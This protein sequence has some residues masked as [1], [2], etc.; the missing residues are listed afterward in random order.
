MRASCFSLYKRADRNQDCKKSEIEEREGDDIALGRFGVVRGVLAEG[1]EAGKRGDEGARAADVDAQQQLAVAFGE[2]RQ[3]HR[4]GHVTDKLTGKGAYDQLVLCQQSSEQLAH[5]LDPRHISGKDEEE[6]EG[7]KQRIIDLF[8]R[9]AIHEEQDGGDHGESEKIGDSAE[10]DGDGERKKSKIYRDSALGQ[11]LDIPFK[12]QRLGL[13]EDQAADGD[14][15]D[16]NQKGDEHYAH[17]LKGGYIEFG[18]E[19]KILRVSEGGQHSAEVGGDVLHNEGERHILFLVGRMQNEVSQ[20]Q[21]G[22]ERHIVGYEHRA[23]E[24]DVDQRQHAHPRCSEAGDDLLRQGVEKA[25]VFQRADHRQHAEKAGQ[26]L[27]VEISDIF[28]VDRHRKSR[29][30]G[31]K[32]GYRHHGV[33]SCKCK[34]ERYYADQRASLYLY[35]VHSFLRSLLNLYRFDSIAHRVPLG[36]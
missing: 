11:L 35:A 2:L 27:E 7:Q 4:R 20:R 14:Q 18:I 22:Q 34:D 17:K 25:Y 28:G 9:V 10:Y 24:G 31:G 3:E 19:V 6:N 26:G 12:L 13:D 21:E 5:G 8:Q 36:Y 29:Q 33:L 32:E 30:C 15:R 1:D 23:D 16:G